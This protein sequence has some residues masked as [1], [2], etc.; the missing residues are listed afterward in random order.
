MRIVGLPG[1]N[2]E[3][4]AWLEVLLTNLAPRDAD[5]S[6]HRYGH[7]AT[8]SKPDLP[9]EI[10][11]ATIGGADLVVAKSLGT[12]VLLGAVSAGNVPRRAVL[13]G[14]PLTACGP[15]EKDGFRA[16]AERLPCCF[17][18]QRQ[19]FTGAYDTLATLLGGAPA[20]LEAV[21]GSDHVYAD[22]DQLA[23]LIADWREG[24][25]GAASHG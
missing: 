22:T 25:G 4:E 14:T 18:Q 6:V 11:S 17:I 15:E 2:P 16:L 10:A 12:L 13:I 24:L 23:R 5:V 8:G 21:A 3:T 20:T 1:R 9:A 7:W 19:D